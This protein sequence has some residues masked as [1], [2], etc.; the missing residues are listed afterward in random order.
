[1]L[2]EVSSLVSNLLFELLLLVMGSVTLHSRHFA[3]HLLDLEVLLIEELLLSL[4][5]NTK[6]VNVG[7]KIS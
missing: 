5:L 2:L 7:L 6:L 3:L 1:V 4:L